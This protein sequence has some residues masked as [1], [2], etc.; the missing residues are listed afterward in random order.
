MMTSCHVCLTSLSAL[1]PPL[2]YKNK[3]NLEQNSAYHSLVGK[4]VEKP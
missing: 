3:F 2:G 1:T 4:E